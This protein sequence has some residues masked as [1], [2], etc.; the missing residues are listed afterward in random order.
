MNTNEEQVLME[1]LKAYRAARESQQASAAIEQTV[2]E[3]FRSSTASSD[4]RSLMAA[5]LNGHRAARVSKRYAGN[6]FLRWWGLVAAA[7]L[8]MAIGFTLQ[9]VR[10]RPPVNTAVKPLAGHIANP[11]TVATVKVPDVQVPDTPVPVVHAKRRVPRVLSARNTPSRSAPAN[12]FIALP[13]AP[14]FQQGDRAQVYRV[15]VPQAS[16]AVFGVPI[17]GDRVSERVN[18]D[19]VLGEDGI[20][21]AI[22]FVQ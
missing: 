16:L 19:V 10:S 15:Q 22:R 9:N 11:S 2:L 4:K 20:V 3:E 6:A 21:R 7:V 8:L 14:P 5:A 17:R 1:A 18:A 13:Y 12:D